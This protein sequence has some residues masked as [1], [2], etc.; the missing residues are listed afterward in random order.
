M[1]ITK[2]ILALRGDAPVGIVLKGAMTL[3]WGKF[4]SQ[5]G[6]FVMG[7]NAKEICEHDRMVREAVGENFLRIGCSMESMLKNCLN[8]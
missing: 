1:K 2:K 7:A 8:A 5:R 4:V 3:D 6:P